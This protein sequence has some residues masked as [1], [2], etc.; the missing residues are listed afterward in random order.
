MNK[1]LEISR[2]ILINFFLIAPLIFIPFSN[3]PFELGKTFSYGLIIGILGIYFVLKNKFNILLPNKLI[4]S[5]FF[6][7]VVTNIFSNDFTRS[8]VGDYPRFSD[9]VLPDLIV[10]LTIILV[11]NLFEKIN[12]PKAI[13]QSSIGIVLISIYQ[14]I[15]QTERISGTLGQ[16]NFLG[17][18]ISLSILYQVKNYEKITQTKEKFLNV[19]YL[20]IQVFVLIK[21]GSLTSFISL[22]SIFSYLLITKKLNL[23][24][25]LPTAIGLIVSISLF[26]NIFVPKV[27]DIYYQLRDRSQTTI[28]DSLLIR[29]ALWE[30]TINRSFSEYKTILFGFGSTYF[31]SDFERHRTRRLDNYSEYFLFYDKPHNYFLEILFSNGLPIFLFFLYIIFKSLKNKSE[32]NVYIILILIFLFFNWMDVYLKIIFFILINQNQSLFKVENTKFKYSLLLLYFLVTT[33]SFQFLVADYFNFK[34]NKSLANKINPFVEEYK[35]IN[36]SIFYNSTNPRIQA[37]GIKYFSGEELIKFKL[38]LKKE[39]PNNLPMKLRIEN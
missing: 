38:F 3:A 33:I 15:S 25:I 32:N 24:I 20:W 7:F 14:S 16:S 23:K 29:G 31:I 27:K 5:Y 34:N 4:S 12:I 13:F 22:L 26:G 10:F 36:P 39:Y 35:T 21:S 28:S 17:I 11:A 1:S 30:T 18:F 2:R 19:L 37:Q 8:L 9:G 6:L